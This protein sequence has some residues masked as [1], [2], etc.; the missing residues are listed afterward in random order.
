VAGV[1]IIEVA[2][3]GDSDGQHG[4]DKGLGVHG[5]PP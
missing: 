1:L 2:E 3:H 4:D 5:C